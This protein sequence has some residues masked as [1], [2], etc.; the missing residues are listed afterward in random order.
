[1]KFPIFLIGLVT[2][3]IGALPVIAENKLL[4]ESLSFLPAS[5]IYYSALIILIGVL[6]ILYG[7]SK[8]AI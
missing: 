1:M 7:F 8:G 2:T 4:P 5:G 6:T 3:F